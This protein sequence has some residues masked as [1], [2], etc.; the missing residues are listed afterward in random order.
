MYGTVARMKVKPGMFDKLRGLTMSED[1]M[2]VP[3]LITT[4]VY[5]MDRDPN[6]LMMAVIF[7][8]K[9][10]YLKN[11]GSPEQ[12]ARYEQFVALLQEPPEWNDGEIV[13]PEK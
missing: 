8:D 1:Q 10:A 13:Y 9:D 7:T 6:E 2:S 12:N 3:G 4:Y 5:R 11:A